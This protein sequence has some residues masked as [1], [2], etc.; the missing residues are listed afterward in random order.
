MSKRIHW[1][2]LGLIILILGA[3]IYAALIPDTSLM[4]WFTTDD[5]FYYFVVAR[6]ITQGFGI[7]FDRIG[8][9]N[10]FHPL[11]M[12]ICIPVFSL[13]RFDLILPLRLIVFILGIFNAA[14][15][16]L[17]YRLLQK[18]G[19]RSPTPYSQPIAMTGAVAWAFL[20]RIYSITS[21]GGLESSVS[22]FFLALLFYLAMR[23][24]EKETAS[25]RDMLLLGA[26]GA[27]ALLSRLDNVFIV[28][29]AGLWIVFRRSSFRY[30]IILDITI[31]AL[32][33]FLSFILRL[34]ST[35]P[36]YQYSKSAFV[37]ILVAVAVKIPLY[38]LF[39]LYRR[40][41]A[42]SI[43]R[44]IRQALLAVSI[45]SVIVTTAMLGMLALTLIPGFPRAAVFIDWGLSL[46]FVIAIRLSLYWLAECKP[47]SGGQLELHR[48]SPKSRPFD[49]LKESPSSAD[50]RSSRAGSPRKWTLRS[51][52]GDF[53]RWVEQLPLHEHWK[54][55]LRE[56]VI[57]F[58]ILA[59]V[60]IAYM[61][62]SYTTFGTPT[63]VSGQIKEWWGTLPDNVYGDPARTLPAFL[64][65]DPGVAKGPWFL[66]LTPLDQFSSFLPNSLRF[67]FWLVIVLLG[68]LLLKINH[69]Y[70]IQTIN[71][72]GILPLFA[73]CLIQFWTYSARA[74]V[75]MRLWYWVPYLLFTVLALC[76]I[77][78]ALLRLV[79]NERGRRY[80]LI[81]ASLVVAGIILFDF[82]NLFMRLA[83][84]P[85]LVNGQKGYLVNVTQLEN[86]TEPG[87]I[88]G[89][90]GGGDT[91]Y[92]V[93]DR[94]IVNLD[95]LINSYEYFQA[96][97]E[98]KA[99]SYLDKIGL[100]Y[101]YANPYMIAESDPYR[102]NFRDRLTLIQNFDTFTLYKY[103]HP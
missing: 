72:L 61:T 25:A 45:S 28:A 30:Y 74:Y 84:V 103:N 70:V 36:F 44:I 8:L 96:L 100:D 68:I 79:R 76:I 91:A 15:A 94:T 77:A 82:T 40:P 14:T 11:W 3:A 23:M 59:I 64:G 42:L 13:A 55:W 33:V 43:F 41:R 102:Q 32:S 88:I 60:L 66:F 6:N 87:S 21:Q 20:P 95:G 85:E 5:A 90:T 51:G 29:L 24:A 65:I 27:L 86:Q 71:R 63:P 37:M 31:T 67:L 53:N 52:S 50:S 57:Y 46:V 58:G 26:I 99:A 39:E 49:R 98:F 4:N 17:V 34:G 12:L 2:E 73:G 93:R 69:A 47:Q 18:V 83:A 10:G 9:A 19:G 92:F 22:A 35:N 81:S 48:Q 7:T 89:M 38:F 56:G 78:E 62:W 101:I 80:L 75:G 54:A 1:F 97:K 16:V